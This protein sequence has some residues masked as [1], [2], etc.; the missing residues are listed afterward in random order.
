MQKKTAQVAFWA[1]MILV[2]GFDEI[3]LS[4]YIPRYDLAV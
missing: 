3:L 4:H 2:V 1:A